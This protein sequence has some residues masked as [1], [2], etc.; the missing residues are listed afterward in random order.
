ML[1]VAA[2]TAAVVLISDLDHPLLAAAVGCVLLALVLVSTAIRA[3]A[4]TLTDEP[5]EPDQ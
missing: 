2:A 1:L 3:T 5:A 4:S